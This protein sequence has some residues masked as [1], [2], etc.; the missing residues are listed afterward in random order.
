MRVSGIAFM[1]GAASRLLPASIPFRFFGAAAAY[2][3]LAWIALFAGAWDVPHFAGGLGWPLAALHLVTL[4]V[5]VMTAIGASLQLLPVATRRPVASHRWPAAIWWLYTPGVAA[6]A[7]GMGLPAPMLL[8][9]GTIAVS[10]ALVGYAVLLARNLLGGSGMPVVIAHGYAALAAL[11]VVLVTAVSL[12]CAY[13]GVP[14]F[15]RSTALALHLTFASYGFMGLLALGLSYVLVPMFALAAAPD[16]LR[17]RL[18]LMLAVTA[19][20]FAAAAAAGI[21]PQ[22][23]RIAA[24]G[25]GAGAVSLHWR[26]MNAALTTGMRPNLGRSAT[27]MKIGWACLAASLVAGLGVVVDV[28]FDG[29]ATLFGVL[30]VAG[31]LLTFL[32]GVLQRIVPFLASMH[33]APGRRLPPTP[34][35]LTAERPLTIHFTCHLAALALLA[36]A[37]V[38]DN[39]WFA[40]ASAL[41]GS[42]GAVAFGSFFATVMRRMCGPDVTTGAR[43]TSAG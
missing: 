19:L 20:L 13:L 1:G 12:V 24:I 16:E 27:L 10:L 2:H 42:A 7:L 11:V 32:L 18:S 3:L 35:S 37:I 22:P 36:V 39:P 33:R 21:A 9:M 28:P 30:L 5:L 26:L 43:G 17:G 4:G 34:S 14:L 25:T 15:A 23:L 38:A 31:W 40:T 8:A 29:V 6:V 41:A